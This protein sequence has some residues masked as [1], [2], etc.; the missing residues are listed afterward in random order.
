M[1]EKMTPRRATL[2]LH[3]ALI[4]LSTDVAMSLAFSSKRYHQVK[5]HSP[6]LPPPTRTA[7]IGQGTSI[8]QRVV[9]TTFTK[10]SK[11]N[12]RLQAIPPSLWWIMG[13]NLLGAAAVPFISSA[14]NKN[15]GWLS[16]IDRPPWNPPDWLFGPVWSF[17]YSCMGLAA[18]RVYNS[19]H[20]VKTPL[21]ILWVVHFTL[22]LSWAPVFFSLQRFRAA[23]IIS[24]FMVLTLLM[25]LISLFCC[26]VNATAGLLLMPYL[27]WIIF[28]T[29][30]NKDIC[31]RNPTVKGYNNGMLQSQIQKLQEDAAKYADS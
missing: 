31:R 1:A 27:A 15:G 22:N 5:I 26:N 28:A 12:F 19:N 3:L 24:C 14:T 29:F 10:S 9:T 2:L 21:M 4:V 13:H 11:S 25:F 17:L 16:K 6:S 30:L 20:T 8:H 18:S 7:R 23:L